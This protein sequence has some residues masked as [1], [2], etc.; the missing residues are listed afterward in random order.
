M[1]VGSMFDAYQEDIREMIEM[2]MTYKE[3]VPVLES[4]MGRQISESGLVYYCNK[5]DIHS[6]REGNHFRDRLWT[7]CKYHRYVT[8]QAGNRLRLCTFSWR[9]IAN[10]CINSPRW[11]EK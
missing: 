3:I 1:R 4:M 5:N 10:V 2:G 7:D 9:M 6:V 11:C 8:G